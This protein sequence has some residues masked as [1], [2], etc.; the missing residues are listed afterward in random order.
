MKKLI[1]MAA[2]AVAVIGGA[3]AQKRISFRADA[4]VGFSAGDYKVENIGDFAGKTIVGYRFSGNVEVPLSAGLYVSPGLAFQS[5][6]TKTDLAGI[7]L[8]GIGLKSLKM[9]T[10]YVEIP[11]HLGYRVNLLNLLSVAVQ[12]GPYFSYA[13]SNEATGTNANGSTVDIYQQGLSQLTV[14]G[15]KFDMGL[16]AAAMV[17]YS[18]I[19]LLVGADFGLVNSLKEVTALG[20][21]LDA[22][23]K[24]TSFHV[25]LGVRF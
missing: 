3:S 9:Q 15:N 4:A 25:G 8:A 2:L 20:Q 24:N 7:A 17:E 13:I 6:G 19:Y 18:K 21:D 1:M 14:K 11:V 12:A 16:G 5:K 22:T 10:H 23:L